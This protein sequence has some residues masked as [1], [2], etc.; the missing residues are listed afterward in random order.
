M[1]TIKPKKKLPSLS[2]LLFE[3][4]AVIVLT[5]LLVLAYR[6]NVFAGTMVAGW[7]LIIAAWFI[8]AMR[9]E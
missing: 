8:S 4:G 3:V 9:S 1:K 6:F 5:T 2:L 7:Y